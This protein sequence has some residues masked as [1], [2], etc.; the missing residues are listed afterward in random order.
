LLAILLTGASQDGAEGMARIAERGGLTVV[1]DPDEAQIRTM[2]RAA[3]EAMTPDL[4]LPLQ[5][6]GELLLK[7][8]KI[9][10]NTKS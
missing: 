10:C 4:I 1:Q 8:E 6:I 7:L 5:G 9:G 3:L 2:P